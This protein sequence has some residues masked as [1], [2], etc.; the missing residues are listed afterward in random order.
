[1][2]IESSFSQAIEKNLASGSKLLIASLGAAAAGLIVSFISMIAL[3][4]KIPQQDFS[5]PLGLSLPGPIAG[6]VFMFVS[7]LS[8]FGAWLALRRARKVIMRIIVDKLKS[9]LDDTWIRDFQSILFESSAITT[10]PSVIRT[11]CFFASALQMGAL[12]Y[13]LVHAKGIGSPFG[14]FM[15]LLFYGCILTFP[16]TF[17]TFNRWIALFK[18]ESYDKENIGKIL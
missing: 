1:M 10:S 11:I 2:A 3:M 9:G 15:A 18:P 5:T 8:G 13:V 17:L 6:W 14:Y 4:G 16:F 7:M 12:S